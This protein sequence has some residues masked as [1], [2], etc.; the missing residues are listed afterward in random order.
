[1]DMFDFYCL[2]VAVFV[3]YVTT[4]RVTRRERSQAMVAEWLETEK[5]RG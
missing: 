1:M 4:P 2:L 3:A 5:R